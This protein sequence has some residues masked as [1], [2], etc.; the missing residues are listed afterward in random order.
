MKKRRTVLTLVLAIIMIIGALIFISLSPRL[1]LEEELA[2]LQTR[3][4]Q[5]SAQWPGDT[6]SV[7]YWDGEHN[8]RLWPPGWR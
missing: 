5:L 1:H 2:I 7:W 3:I 6:F 4:G 8:V